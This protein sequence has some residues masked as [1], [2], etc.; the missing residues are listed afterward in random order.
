MQLFI[1]NLL[2]TNL[3]Y[4][5]SIPVINASLLAVYTVIIGR[6]VLGA[7]GLRGQGADHPVLRF[8]EV[9]VVIEAADQLDLVLAVCGVDGKPGIAFLQNSG[10]KLYCYHSYFKI[11]KNV[12]N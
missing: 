11:K 5:V 8:S 6:A 10:P 2:S 4:V 3:Q 7:Q 9:I 1:C 12:Y